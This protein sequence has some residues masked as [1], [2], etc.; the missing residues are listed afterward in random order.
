MKSWLDFE[1]RFRDLAPQL[2]LYRL[3]ASRGFSGETWRIAGGNRNSAVRNFEELARLA[4]K[5]LEKV[6]PGLSFLHKDPDWSWYRALRHYEQS[7]F[8]DML[9]GSDMEED[10]T[11]VGHTYMD[12][13]HDFCKVSADICLRLNSEFPIPEG[14]SGGGG[15]NTSISIHPG[16]V[17]MSND[18]YEIGQAGAVGPGA[19]AENVTFNQIWKKSAGNIDVQQLA[20]ELTALREELSKRASE[21]DHFVAL[22]SLAAAEKAA[23]SGDGPKALEHLKKA[24]AWVW[25]VGTK[26]GIGVATAAAKSALGF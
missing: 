20:L 6:S 9:I 19:H 18:R 17:Y 2:R 16:G 5:T 4:G 8:R 3:D 7:E 10:G 15:V 1:K 23:Q 11:V 24:G 21:S 25:D 12:I 26:I 14:Q 22:G 13:L